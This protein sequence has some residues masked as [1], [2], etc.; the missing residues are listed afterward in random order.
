MN[1]GA[2]P[3]PLIKIVDGPID[4]GGIVAAVTD[5]AAGGID[6]FIGTTRNH[7]QGRRVLR[8]EYE[9]YVPM[10]LAEMENIAVEAVRRWGLLRAGAV[11]RNGP[12][13]IG[14]ASV[15]I[16]CSAAHRA[17]AFEACRFVIDALKRDVPIWKKEYYADGE[18][19]VGEPEG[20]PDRGKSG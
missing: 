2:G 9:A 14:E 1:P 17:E 4:I 19:W 3:K 6:L 18:A 12:V 15:A 5:P 20:G 8:L 16:A 10:A 13:G 11:H 7:H